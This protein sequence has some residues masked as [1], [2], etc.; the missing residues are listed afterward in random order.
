MIN[1]NK[2]TEKNVSSKE[3]ETTQEN[4][5]KCTHEVAIPEKWLQTLKTKKN[6]EEIEKELISLNN[7]P[8]PENPIKEYKFELDNFQRVSIS[9]LERG[10]SVIVSAH[11]SS[12]KTAVAEY[13]IAQALNSKSRVV[14][15]SPIKALSNQKYRELKDVFGDVGLITG[16]VSIDTNSSCLVMTT[17]IL[18]NMLY[19]GSEIVRE[20]QYIIF[21]EIHYM[22]DAS[23]GVVW[24]EAII[25]S[26]KNAK[27]VFLSA[28][29]PNALEF[30]EWVAQTHNQ[31][32]HV[33]STETRPVPLRYFLF[34][35]SG[36]G[37]YLTLDENNK[38]YDNNFQ[39]CMDLLHNN[40]EEQ[41]MI[42]KKTGFTM[43]KR[44]KIM[45]KSKNDIKNIITI[46]MR[47][48]FGPVIV[49]SFAR[50]E[51]EA[52]SI[53]F[54]NDNFNTEEQSNLVE[55]IFKNAIEL[56]DEKDQKLPQI[57]LILPI[58]K[59]GI[60]IHH[61]GLL[62]IIKEVIEILFQEGLIKVLFATET[63]SMGLNMPAKTVVFNGIRKFDGTC[64]RS[65][66]SGEFI[67]MSGRAGRRG[68]DKSGNVILMV[69]N[70]TEPKYL[71]TL[72]NGKAKRLN[73]SFKLGYNM[74]LKLLRFEDVDLDHIMS[75]S[76]WQFQ[77][78]KKLPL[79][80]EQCEELEKK[81]A[82]MQIPNEDQFKNYLETKKQINLI[83]NK[84]KYIQNKP[85][86]VLPFLTEGRLIKFKYRDSVEWGFVIN[87]F[88]KR[89]R[90]S[91]NFNKNKKDQSGKEGNENDLLSKNANQIFVEILIPQ[92]NKINANDPNN[93]KKDGNG[94]GNG[95]GKENEEENENDEKKE[96]GNEDG[97]KNKSVKRGGYNKE[98][99]D[100]SI[101]TK[102]RILCSNILEISTIIMKIN[103]NYRTKKN[104]RRF[105]DAIEKIKQK[106]QEDIPILDSIEDLKINDQNFIKYYKQVQIL[107]KI[108]KKHE[109]LTK[110]EQF[111]S[112]LELFQE[113]QK[114]NDQL[115]EIQESIRESENIVMKDQLSNMKKVMKRLGYVNENGLIQTKGRIACEISTGDELLL[116][117]LIFSG[118]FKELDTHQIAAIASCFVEPPRSHEEINL[119]EKLQKPYE[120]ISEMIEF[121]GQ[122]FLECRLIENIQKYKEKFSPSL[123][124]IVHAWTNGASFLDISQMTE[125]FEGDCVRSF[126]RLEELLKQLSVAAK[127][128]GNSELERKFSE[129]TTLMK[130][131]IVFASSLYL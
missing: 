60:G 11:T 100:V 22:K 17:E 89:N 95:N 46:L 35:S 1:P 72:F 5:T 39:K 101:P 131:D 73:S 9:C 43:S 10:E 21:D 104:E 129:A 69:D 28:T 123:M 76:F 62:P 94:N 50:K 112:Q 52:K 102:D 41:T 114:L 63:F 98:R 75:R 108:L 106:Y 83:K 19:R 115:K 20:V 91:N 128:I 99:R 103:L 78:E 119:I 87:F 14:Y 117:E 6:E 26:P 47:K 64:M 96:N 121:L 120:K 18:R 80:N 97:N 111:G 65:V 23:R 71:R 66:D 127:N 33:V 105:K 56:L 51:C 77:N 53:L 74:L 57:Q 13:A 44:R 8:F 4:K 93:K 45:I 67:Q 58:L 79:L 122:V 38:F 40:D 70:H 37:L 86:Y 125:S 31:P 34:P 15:T 81:I 2:N 130:R 32:C 42:D 107:N 124:N 92:K 118:I 110:T 82:D 55:L 116:T 88:E 29:I 24:E 30:A 90:F 7:P 85:L 48:N 3:I 109:E 36:D 16:D 84:M 54:Q 61:S 25:L 59:R 49:F 27:F 126:R 68:L 12:G 113:K